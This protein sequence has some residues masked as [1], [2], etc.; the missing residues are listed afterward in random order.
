MRNIILSIFLLVSL[1]TSS[2]DAVKIKTDEM[3]EFSGQRRIA[4]NWESFK[5]G[6]VHMRLR[7]VDNVLMLDFKLLPAKV[8]VGI[9][10]P[11]M[12]K[13]ANTGLINKLYPQKVTA[14]E[15]GGGAI[16][17]AGSQ[18]MGI[19]VSYDCTP[20]WFEQNK[21]SLIR[22]YSTDEYT[23]IKLNDDEANKLSDMFKLIKSTLASPCKGKSEH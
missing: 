7:H 8:V 14:S 10:N 6:A 21:A 1:C 19:F 11:M 5:G 2:I 4:T 9:E 15:I 12:F 23:D 3:D 13:D 20:E 16:G 17:L 18:A 22:M